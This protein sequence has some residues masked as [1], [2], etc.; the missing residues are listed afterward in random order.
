VALLER[1]TGRRDREGA[2]KLAE[3]LGNLPLALDLAAAYCRRIQASFAHYAERISEL[4]ATTPRGAG[5]PRSVAATFDLAINEAGTQSQAAEAIMAYLAECAPQRIPMT[6]VEGAVEDEADLMRAFAALAEVSLVKHDPFE[7]GTPAVTVHRLVQ[8]VA[9]ARLES[10]GTTRGIVERL[11]ARLGE[12]Y[13]RD[14]L[15]NPQSWPLC[16]QLT[17]HLLA[18]RDSRTGTTS[19]AD[20][21]DLL[22]RAG[23][24]LHRLAAYSGAEALFRRAISTLEGEGADDQPSMLRVLSELG[25]LLQDQGRLAEAQPLF[26]RA[27]ATAERS[28]G[29]DHSSTAQLLNNLGTLRQ[30]QGDFPS[31]RSLLERALHIQE[32]TFGPEHPFTAQVLTNLGILL[33]EQGDFASAQPL[34]Q[35]ALHIQE[36]MLGSDHPDTAQV[37]TNLGRLLRE[38]GDFASAQPLLERA[39]A[40]NE[41]VLGAEHPSTAQALSNLASLLQSKGD[42][43]AAQPLLERALA[44]SEKALGAEHPFTGEVLGNLARLHQMLGRLGEAQALYERALAI[45]EKALG[46]EH[47]RTRQLRTALSSVRSP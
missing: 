43:V 23:L 24:Y 9:R 33:Q 13:P 20:W 31:A 16:A 42:P 28:L 22:E 14:A 38:Q 21:A 1:R 25:S 3:A 8:A 45:C 26:E 44:V 46:P 19:S 12:I 4:I 30:Q 35:R 34:L 2:R 6:L 32:R 11:L 18:Q 27:L 17:P 36:R 29:P 47:H 5:Y 40:I 15:I 7:D 10:R 41:K 37:L 39:L